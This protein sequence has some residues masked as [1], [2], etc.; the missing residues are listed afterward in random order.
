MKDLIH[1]AG[2]DNV[3]VALRDIVAG[4]EVWG[5]DASVTAT[6]DVPRGHKIALVALPAGA[7]V[8]KYGASIGHLTADVAAGAWVH[9]HNLATNLRDE[10]DYVWQAD[11]APVTYPKDGRTF[12]GF[13]RASGGVGIRNDLYVVPM[14][15]CVNGSADIAVSRLRA[16]HP[17][18]LPFDNVIVCKH[19]YGCSQLGGDHE[20]TRRILAGVVRHP[21]AGG[22]LV[23]GLGCENNTMDAF[24]ELL[25][26]VDETR[27]KFLVAQKVDDEIEAAVGLMEQLCEAARGD[28]R[29]DVPLSELRIGLKC[30]GS[31]GFSGV[32]A[33]PLLGM[34]S[35]Y[36]IS[37]GGAAVL[38]EVPEMFGAETRL[39]A[40]AANREVFDA[41]VGL[42]NGFK[43]YFLDAGEPV[44]ENP[45]PGNRDGGITTLEEKSLGCTQKSGTSA[46]VDVLPYGGSIRRPGLSLLDGPGNDLVSSSNLAAAGCQMVLFTTG[47]GTPFG[48]FVPTIKVSTT[49]ELAAA[50]PHWID[51]DA[52]QLFVRDR[53]AVLD[54]LVDKVVAVASGERTH[55]EDGGFQELAIFKTGVTL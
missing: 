9:T 8:V 27:V 14:V 7:D 6:T 51:F 1:L 2:M 44:Y 48:V 50:K 24:R 40:R 53:Q 30:G 17:E 49:S 25:G 45:S 32:T 21:N 41:T 19:P 23:F 54:D 5:E 3:A 4:Q 37:Q 20:A 16:R 35:D 55:N 22:V 33:N 12:A 11:L 38:S 36:L 43:R 15:G 47:R 42:I 39:M 52:G 46:V 34:L 26:P 31:D 10:V 13:R 18:G 28:H 29:E